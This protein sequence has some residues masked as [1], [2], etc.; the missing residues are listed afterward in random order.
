M[1]KIIV[2]TI[3][4]IPYL[5]Y[6]A[7]KVYTND[8]LNRYDYGSTGDIQSYQSPAYTTGKISWSDV[9]EAETRYKRFKAEAEAQGLLG[10]LEA[11]K[12]CKT[13]YSY[14]HGRVLMDSGAEG[15]VTIPT[16]NDKA[17]CEAAIRS[18]YNIKMNSLLQQAAMAEADYRRILMEYNEQG[19]R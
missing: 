4:L 8:D 16:V 9:K 10:Q 3:L 11:L 12:R 1:K 7:D 17:A 18:T 2:I 14:T 5:L 19:K 15:M 6:A 13:T